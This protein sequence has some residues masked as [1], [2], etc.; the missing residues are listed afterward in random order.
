M[1][2]ITI[3]EPQKAILEPLSEVV[4]SP[5]SP[6]TPAMM[7]NPPTMKITP[8]TPPAIATVGAQGGDYKRP[9]SSKG[10]HAV[11]E[12]PSADVKPQQKKPL[13]KKKSEDKKAKRIR[14]KSKVETAL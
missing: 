12:P 6:P 1:K 13:E 7:G 10:R 11:T 14:T 8:E 5:T 4:E 2:L 9:S 3:E